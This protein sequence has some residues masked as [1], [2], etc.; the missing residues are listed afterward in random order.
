LGV[1]G[2]HGDQPKNQKNKTNRQSNLLRETP[3]SS[4]RRGIHSVFSVLG[5]CVERIGH[6]WANSLNPVNGFNGVD[7]AQFSPFLGAFVNSKPLTRKEKS[8]KALSRQRDMTF[9]LQ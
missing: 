5:Q 9:Y 4:E 8:K 2:E 3:K 7:Q 1:V 6:L